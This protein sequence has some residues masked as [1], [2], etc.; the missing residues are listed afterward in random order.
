MAD[1]QGRPGAVRRTWRAVA[2]VALAAVAATACG[3]KDEAIRALEAAPMRA[4]DGGGPSGAPTP[5]AGA[6]AVEDTVAAA[7]PPGDTTGVTDTTLRIGAHLPESV[8][9][10]DLNAIVPIRKMVTAYWNA[11]NREGGIHGREVEMVVADD[12][13]NPSTAI[14]GCKELEAA[15][16]FF[17]FG[18]AGND[19]IVACGQYALE[20]GIPYLAVGASEPGLIG[21]PGYFTVSLTREQEAR[22]AVRYIAAEL[23]GT[24]VPVALLRMNTPNADSVR[25]AFLDEA[26]RLGV[27]VAVDD[28]VDK[29][30]NPAQMQA[31]CIKLRQND[32]EVVYIYTTG[33]VQYQGAVAC[34]AQDYRPQ[35]IGPSNG[36]MC[37]LDPPFGGPEN[38]GCIQ[39]STTHHVDAVDHAFEEQACQE[40]AASYPGEA[41][42]E[43]TALA[44]VPVL[45]SVLD[46]FRATLD[47]AGRDLT[48][49]SYIERT[50]TLVYDNGLSNPIDFP[51]TRNVP[52][53]P[54][55]DPDEGQGQIGGRGVVVWRSDA[56]S[57]TT[58][59]IDSEWK[60]DW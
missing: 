38:D 4:V 12:G 30:P 8:S 26:E 32:V 19:Q 44:S 23:D 55:A 36:G 28:A 27:D 58:V 29:E 35:W 43:D 16:V 6:P 41:C 25:A 17:M 52:G 15:E 34:N 11:R 21:R 37:S 1:T 59:E 39:F 24:E 31:E 40:W 2:L 53:L 13:Y 48:R 20:R 50:A 60:V 33:L 42:P 47:H 22:L 49:E 14:E 45:W 3:A 10:V 7:A 54:G 46:M 51:A 9:G 5:S 56:A 57:G 18:Y